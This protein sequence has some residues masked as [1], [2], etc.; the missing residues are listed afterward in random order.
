M[1]NQATTDNSFQVFIK[2]AGRSCNL[3]CSYCYYSAADEPGERNTI[4]TDEVLERIIRNHFE[5][6]PGEECNFSWH[7]GEPLLA[8]IDFYRKAFDLQTKFSEGLIPFRNGIQTNGTLLNDEWCRFLKEKDFSVGISIDGPE[9]MHNKFRHNHDG[10]KSFSSVMK[11]LDLLVKHAINIEILTVVGSHNH[12][13]PLLVYRFL[14]STGIKYFT[15]IPLVEKSLGKGLSAFSA[16]P[17]KFGK[18]LSSI[19]DEWV[20]EDI[21]NVKIQILEEALRTAFSQDH[22]LC[23]FKKSCGR[24][25]VIEKNGDLFSCDHFTFETKPAGNIFN[26]SLREFLDSDSQREFGIKKAKS[27]PACC[28]ECDVLAM[29]NGECPKNRIMSAP[30]GSPGLNYLCEGYKMFF[31]HIKPFAEAV[32]QQWISSI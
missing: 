29:C 25:P 19:F 22:T 1:E 20:E 7:G 3:S 27:L 4:M 5:A 9:D 26:I 13:E 31:R 17:V 8:G 28:R 23:I 15:F 16:D 18:F 10:R 14:K 12:D 32:R 2:P 11:G 24:V 21:G 30:D 6:Y